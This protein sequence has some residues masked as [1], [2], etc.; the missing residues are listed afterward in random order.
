MRHQTLAERIRWLRTQLGLSQKEFAQLIGKS[1]RTVQRWERGEVKI[2]KSVLQHIANVTGAS[3][4]W[5]ETGKGPPFEREMEK[6]SPIDVEL[7]NFITQKVLEAYEKGVIPHNVDEYFLLDLIKL[8]YRKLKPLKDKK[9]KELA[10]KE[11]EKLL[12]ATSGG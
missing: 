7:L 1:L 8:A 4:E 2:P 11:L 10:I 12:L 6:E 9:E 5:L 3:L